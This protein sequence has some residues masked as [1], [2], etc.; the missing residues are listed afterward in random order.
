MP[1]V[2]EVEAVRVIGGDRPIVGYRHRGGYMQA[3][4]LVAHEVAVLSV[5][6]S[7]GV[8]R[9]F[10]RNRLE[11]GGEKLVHAEAEA[12]QRGALVKFGH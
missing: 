7:D 1:V 3:V 10:A 2:D 11:A 9:A 12:K 5:T 6:V 8:G 4:G